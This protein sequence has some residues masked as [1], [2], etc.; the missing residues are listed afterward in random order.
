MYTQALSNAVDVA[1]RIALFINLLASSFNYGPANFRI[2][3]VGIGG[4]VAGIA[5]ERVNGVIPHVTGLLVISLH[6]SKEFLCPAV[7]LSAGSGLG[8]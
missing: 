1:E 6:S 5:A 4:H 7:H 3:G 2:V 8:I